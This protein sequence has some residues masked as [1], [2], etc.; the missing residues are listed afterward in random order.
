[1][2]RAIQLSDEEFSVAERPASGRGISPE[3]L[4]Q[5]LLD[6]VWEAECARYDAAFENDTSWQETA[7]AAEAGELPA[8]TIYRSTAEFLRALGASEDE[9][10]AVP[11][12]SPRR[13]LRG[14]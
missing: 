3:Q 4:I 7:R 2:G 12:H 1:M 6:E 13:P 14:R 9:Q 11:C 10:E 5:A 8:G